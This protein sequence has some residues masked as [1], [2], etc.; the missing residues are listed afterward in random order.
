MTLVEVLWIAV[1]LIWSGNMVLSLI[2]RRKARKAAL[3]AQ[4]VTVEEAPVEPEHEA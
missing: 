4:Q 1:G 2:A 3:Q